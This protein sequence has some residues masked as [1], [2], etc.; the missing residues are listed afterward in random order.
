MHS[1]VTLWFV[2]AADPRAVLAAEP[3]A[4]RGF[5]RKYLAQ[6]NPAW[7]LTHIGDFDM[8]RSADPGRDEFYIGGYEGLAVVR[9]ATELTRLSEVPDAVRRLIGAA[10]VYATLTRPDGLGGIAHWAGG[11]LRRSFC[12]TRETVFEDIGLPHPAE[13]PF[14]EGTTEATG[15]QL[16]FIPTELAAA[17]ARAWLGF[18]VSPDDVDIPVSAFAVDGRPTPRTGPHPAPRTAGA[19]TD[20]DA[21]ADTPVYDDYA[22]AAPRPSESTAQLLRAA[23]RSVG[24][25]VRLGARGA[26]TLSHRVGDEVR[27]RARNTGRR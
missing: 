15:I 21:D 3:R 4:D 14:W 26:Q 16:P 11:D 8:N 27:R 5:A 13:A 6:L 2:T 9:T 17:V 18:S 24:R 7:P 19:G 22:A 1:V 12:A 20:S 25:G 23:A 10:D